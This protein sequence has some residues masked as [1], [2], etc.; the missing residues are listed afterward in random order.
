MYK[1]VNVEIKET[2]REESHLGLILV[3]FSTR[4]ISSFLATL[5]KI[6]PLTSL[7]NIYK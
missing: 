7:Y 3:H 6:P 2:K 1:E 4:A 5:A